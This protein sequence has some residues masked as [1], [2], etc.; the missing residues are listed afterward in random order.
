MNLLPKLTGVILHTKAAD[1][2]IHFAPILAEVTRLE[3]AAV[4]RTDAD[5]TRTPAP[6]TRRN[7][8]HRRAA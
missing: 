3:A 2:S 7:R 5:R 4:F 1:R 8:P 6:S